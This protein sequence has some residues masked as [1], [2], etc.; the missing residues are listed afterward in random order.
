MFQMNVQGFIFSTSLFVLS[1]A[2]IIDEGNKPS[3]LPDHGGLK[4]FKVEESSDEQKQ[5]VKHAL[6][7]YSEALKEQRVCRK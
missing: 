3:H 6:Q 1:A 2:E 7:Q 5:T 4:Y